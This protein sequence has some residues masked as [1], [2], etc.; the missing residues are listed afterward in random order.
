MAVSA[1]RTSRLTKDFGGG[2]GVFGV[3]L[4]VPPEQVFGLVG[5]NG[6]GKS[7]LVRCLMG[8]IRPT[9]GS[10]F[11]LGLDCLRDPVEVARKVGYLPDQ[12]PRFGDMR[13]REVVAYLGGMRGGI[14][15]NRVQQL[16]DRFDLD[17]SRR[18]RESSTGDQRKL[19]ILLAFMHD[20]ELLILDE[21]FAHIDEQCEREL[22]ALIEESRAAGRT[23][24]LTDPVP[25]AVE[26]ICEGLAML[27]AGR[28]VHDVGGDDLALRA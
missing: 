10:A 7:T 9:G 27:R 5:P 23:V 28:I 15:P 1:I 16:A 21:P 24:F 22:Q 19:C 14:D 26:E 13:G 8:L 6:A 4:E 3:E 12:A 20:P 25:S 17:L 18:F 11:V 2:H